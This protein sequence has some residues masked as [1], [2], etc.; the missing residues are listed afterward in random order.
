[1]NIVPKQIR[2]KRSKMLRT[3][4]VKIRRDFY[5]QLNTLHTVLFEGENKKG[6]MY[7]F[8]ENY[9]KVRTPWNP[10]LTNKIKVVKLH[11]IDNEGYLRSKDL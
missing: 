3:L 2:S 7:G 9:V 1:M 10:E 8:S 4:S 11:E 6:Y 5:S